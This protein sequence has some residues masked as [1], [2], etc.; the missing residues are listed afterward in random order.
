M[1]EARTARAVILVEGISDRIALETR[2]ALL[3]RDLGAE[4]VTIVPV[5]GFGEIARHLA[6]FGPGGAG[7]RLSGL[8][9]ADAAL[10]VR[11][12]LAR[13]G[14]GHPRTRADM[15]ALG[16]FVC[17]RTLEEELIRAVGPDAVLPVLDAGGDLR[18]FRT[19]ARQPGWRDRPL[20]DQLRRFLCA[21]GRRH[22]HYAGALAAAAPPHR[23]PAPL[24]AAL[25][26]ATEDPTR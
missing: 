7:L 4:R 14:L 9:D 8:C 18:S 19:F 21:G 13:A 26:H 1:D 12:A 6:R 25:S 24:Y 2:A 11:R 20:A 23:F 15:A 3:G 16:F 17:D 22:L 10:P 5:G